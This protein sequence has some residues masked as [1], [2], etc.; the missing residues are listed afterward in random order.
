VWK[1]KQFQGGKEFIMRA[2]FSLPSVQSCEYIQILGGYFADHRKV[3]MISR[4]V[5][6]IELAT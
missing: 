1:I 2:H 5:D 3:R 6:D 4:Q